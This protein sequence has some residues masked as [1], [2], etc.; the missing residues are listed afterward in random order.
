MELEYKDN[1]R[2]GR[3]VIILGFVLALAA[4]AAA[5]Y[6]INQAQ[7]QAAAGPA[8]RVNVVVAARTISARETITADAVTLKEVPLDIADTS[9]F[10]DVN[11]VIN[12]VPAV[13]ILSGQPVTAN[14][15]ASTSEGGQFSVLKPEETVSPDS[16]FW[17]AVAI[18]VAPDLAVGGLLKPG[19][20]VDVF[21]TASVTVPPSLETSGRYVSDKTTKIVYQ[22]VEIL[23]REQDYYIIRLP[24]AQAEEIAHL[25]AT[26]AV[27]FT[28]ALRP[29]EDTR[30]ADA[31][32][33]G[34]TT[35]LIISRY[36]LPIP[37]PITV[38]RQTVASTAP[39]APS[40]PPSAAPSPTPAPSS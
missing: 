16:P 15:L 19:M 27:T 29:A 12:R 2:R 28:L 10:G 4:G 18:T 31:S 14:L 25:Q 30:V 8:Q 38:G 23:A 11:Q 5:F 26:A 39:P 3:Y 21:L 1:S 20:T 17:R 40:A 35:N 32:G 34:E 7:Q 24:L 6:L 37:Q 36:G 9:T 22:D 13:T 33:L